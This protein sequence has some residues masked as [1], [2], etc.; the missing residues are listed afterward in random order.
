[1]GLPPGRVAHG[2]HPSRPP[3]RA[4]PRGSAAGGDELLSRVATTPARSTSRAPSGWTIRGRSVSARSR[5][6][7]DVALSIDAPLVR[8]H[9]PP[10]GEREK[11]SSAVGAL[12]RSAGI[13][14]RGR[15]GGRVPPRLPPR[16]RRAR[17]RSRRW[18]S[19]SACCASGSR[20][21]TGRPVRDRG[22][23][24]RSRPR[25]ARRRPRD[26]G[27]NGL[28]AAGARLRPHARDARRRL[29]R[30]GCSPRRSRQRTPSSSRERR[31]TS[32]SPTSRTRTATRRST[33]PTARER[34]APTRCERPSS[35]SSAPRP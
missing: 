22:H 7:A 27:A 4:R 3:R 6:S 28:G 35:A 20:A 5:A 29:P 25:L 33:F 9:G 12:D 19:S 18:S 21:R 15:R 31:S 11:F 34:S 13:A 23:G 16:P 1:M 17:T 24:P 32:T 30:I 8:L 14:R 10:G 2:T 26:L